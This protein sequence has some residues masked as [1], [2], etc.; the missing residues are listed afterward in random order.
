MR[1][2]PESQAPTKPLCISIGERHD[3][4]SNVSLVHQLLESCKAK[5]LKAAFYS[6]DDSQ[7]QKMGRF[8]DDATHVCGADNLPAN[9]KEIANAVDNNPAHNNNV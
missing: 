8:T 9:W 1:N 3:D 5:G 2:S 4:F 7:L 6:E